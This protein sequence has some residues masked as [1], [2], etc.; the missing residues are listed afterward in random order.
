MRG[1][2]G[3]ICR[4]SFEKE[5][6]LKTRFALTAVTTLLFWLNYQNETLLTPNFIFSQVGITSTTLAL[7][8]LT[9][10]SSFSLE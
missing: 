9:S 6:D 8:E 2:W 1:L 4:G 5:S 10:G 3:S 7:H